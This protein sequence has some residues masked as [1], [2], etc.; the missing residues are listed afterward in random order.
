MHQCFTK[1]WC[2]SGCNFQSNIS[3]WNCLDSFIV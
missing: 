3:K 2:R 1:V